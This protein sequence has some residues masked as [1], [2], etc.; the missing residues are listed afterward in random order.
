[1]ALHTAKEARELTPKLHADFLQG[2]VDYI[3]GVLQIIVEEA[4]AKNLTEATYKPN[5]GTYRPAMEIAVVKLQ[6][7]GYRVIGFNEHSTDIY[8]SWKE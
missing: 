3:L 6:E 1:M 4:C 8:F 2:H 5:L 7:A